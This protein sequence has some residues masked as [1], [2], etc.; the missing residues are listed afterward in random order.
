MILIL[1]TPHH[2]KEVFI[3]RRRVRIKF[4]IGKGVVHAVHNGIG[5]RAQVRRALRDI[6]KYKKEPLPR[7]AH[8]KGFMRGVPVLKKRLGKQG[9]V[10][11]GY[12]SDEDNNQEMTY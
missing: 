1:G 6:G 4:R 5:P 8:G 11:V 12:K 10:P 7:L 2:G 9:K 3:V